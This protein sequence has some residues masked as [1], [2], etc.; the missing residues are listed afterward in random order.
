MRRMHK[1]WMRIAH[2]SE[3]KSCWIDDSDGRDCR[4]LDAERSRL[5]ISCRI[6]RIRVSCGGGSA[7]SDRV[8]FESR[9]S[10]RPRSPYIV[11]RLCTRETKDLF[12]VGVGARADDHGNLTD[13]NLVIPHPVNR[14]T[15]Y[16]IP[17]QYNDVFNANVMRV[18]FMPE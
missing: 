14:S 12:R 5:L 6:W 3:G 4:M 10:R 8:R 17:Y 9:M 18:I 2:A 1:W 7:G 11:E 16:G 13:T 15:T